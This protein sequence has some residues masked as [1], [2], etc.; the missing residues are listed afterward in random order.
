[1]T[2][3]EFKRWLKKQGC[4]FQEGKG[5]GKG[6]HLTVEYCGRKTTLPFHGGKEMGEGLRRAIIKQLDIK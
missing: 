4:T 1:M 5:H 2:Y 6:S 3:A